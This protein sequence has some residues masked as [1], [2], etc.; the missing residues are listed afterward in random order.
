ME[1]NWKSR[2][3][4]PLLRRPSRKRSTQRPCKES[5]KKRPIGVLYLHGQ[6]RILCCL[7]SGL[8]HCC[9]SCPLAQELPTCCGCDPSSPK[10][11]PPGIQ[12]SVSSCPQAAPYGI[13]VDTISKCSCLWFLWMP[14]TFLSNFHVLCHLILTMLLLSPFYLFFIFFG[15]GMQKFPG[16]GLTLATAVT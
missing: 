3:W 12:K 1:R 2:S 9:G 5:S 8:G 16:Q 10:K 15:C 14:G 6:L 4:C 7:C 13:V 11:E